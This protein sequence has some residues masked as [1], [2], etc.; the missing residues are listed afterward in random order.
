MNNNFIKAIRFMYDHI[1]QPITLDA[2]A[3]AARLSIS[4]LKR[5]FLEKTNLSVGAFLR[6][7]RMELAFC[8]L[9]NKQDSILEIALNSG[10]ED[11]SAFSRCFK[12]TFGYSPTH[13]RN[14]INIIHELEAVTLQEPEFVTLNDISI[15]AVTKQGLYF[16]CAPQAWH[17]L[18]EK[19]QTINIDDDFGGMFI[20][21]GHDNPHDGEIAHDQVRFSAGVSFLDTNLGIDKITLPSGLY[22]KFNYEGKI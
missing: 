10:F 20:G 9:Q 21:I 1:D 17:A 5:L 8:S 12:D 14:K 13:A 11:H 2:V 7:M 6:K 3:Q 22:A 16:E 15:Q 4:S 19:L 18:Q